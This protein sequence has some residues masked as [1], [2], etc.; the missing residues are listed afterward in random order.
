M[1]RLLGTL[2]VVLGCAILI[3]DVSSIDV[4]AFSLSASHGIHVSDLIGGA[5]VVAGIVTLWTAPPR[6]TD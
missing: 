1:R 6:R 2:L 4:V 3:V 5:A